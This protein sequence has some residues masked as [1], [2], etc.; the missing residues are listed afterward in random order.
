MSIEE[1]P[2]RKASQTVILILIGNG[3]I[4]NIGRIVNKMHCGNC[5]L[6]PFHTKI[7]PKKPNLTPTCGNVASGDRLLLTFGVGGN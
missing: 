3:L 7:P 5:T 2:E 6:P 1:K 4:H